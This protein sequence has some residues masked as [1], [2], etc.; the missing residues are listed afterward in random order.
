MDLLSTVGNWASIASFVMGVGSS[1]KKRTQ[2]EQ[3]DTSHGLEIVKYKNYLS[4]TKYGTKTPCDINLFLAHIN[5]IKVSGTKKNPIVDVYFDDKHFDED[6][7]CCVIYTLKNSG[8]TGIVITDIV[9]LFQKD[10]CL[11]DIDDA[12][13][14]CE[15]HILNYS[16]YYEKSVKPGESFTLKICYHKDAII[17]GPFSAILHIGIVDKDGKLWVQ[18]LFAPE[19]KIYSSRRISKKDYKNELDISIAEKCFANPALW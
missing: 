14:H 12:H 10:T 8:Q 7:W 6:E 17:V 16:E 5:D 15:N 13:W 18:P 3:T 9:C 2:P 1:L 19:N 4:R 11:F